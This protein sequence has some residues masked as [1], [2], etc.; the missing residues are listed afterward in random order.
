MAK[1]Q[2]QLETSSVQYANASLH[3][4]AKTVES[5][6]FPRGPVPQSPVREAWAMRSLRNLLWFQSA[7]KSVREI[8]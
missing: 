6:I 1:A 3:A 5:P 8:S 2:R 7:C 4:G